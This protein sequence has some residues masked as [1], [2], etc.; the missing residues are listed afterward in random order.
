[1]QNQR[2]WGTAIHLRSVSIALATTLITAIIPVTP[3]AYFI[4]GSNTSHSQARGE[5]VWAYTP[6]T[7]QQDQQEDARE[8]LLLGAEQFQRQQFYDA[9]S[10]WEEA[11]SLYQQLGDGEG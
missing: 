6:G 3:R 9:L 11:R 1:M 5:F 7:F 8:L 10:S 4:Y 2:R